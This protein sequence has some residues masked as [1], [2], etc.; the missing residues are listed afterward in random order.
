[1]GQPVLEQGGYDRYVV[2]GALLG[3]E[4][5]V[6][7]FLELGA[8][9]D[10]RDPVV[11]QRAGQPRAKALR[12]VLLFDVER[13]QIGVEV[14]AWTVHLL[15]S[16]AL[17]LC[18]TV[19]REVAQV[20]ERARD[21]DLGLQQVA[22]LQADLLENAHVV[23]YKCHT[24]S[25]AHVVPGDHGPKVLQH[26]EGAELR[27]VG[28]AVV[29]LL[30][31]HRRCLGHRGVALAFV[32]PHQRCAGVDLGVDHSEDLAH[33]TR[34]GSPYC[35]LHLH[36]LEDDDRRAGLDG[37]A[38]L[39][40]HR[41]HHG[42]RRGSDDAG[43]VVDDPAAG[44]V[45]DHEMAA[46]A[47][48]AAHVVAPP[49]DHESALVAV[50]PVAVDHRHLVVHIEPV[51]LRTD[52]GDGE[53][54][55]LALVGELD[56]ATDDVAGPRAAPACRGQERRT[57]H[58]LLG[59]VH[60]DGDT[61]Q[62]DVGVNRRRL[63]H[64]GT[65]PVE[66]LRVCLAGNDL[67]AREQ[68]EQER[69][70]RRPALDENGRLTQRTTQSGQRLGTVTPP[71]D[72]LRHHGVVLRGDDLAGCD[73]GVHPDA[74]AGGRDEDD[75]GAR[76]RREPLCGVLS[77]QPCLDGVAGLAGWLARQWFSHGHQELELDQVQSG[78]GLGDGVLHLEPCVDLH[79][80]KGLVLWLV[81]EL[82]RARTLV[83]GG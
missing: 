15:V 57:F 11:L 42:R 66:P 17:L 73:R 61:E 76:R 32:Q 31:V 3:H 53:G 68:V 79:E 5:A 65:D 83:P 8:P 62:G 77:V 34:S 30:E 6:D 52:L 29:V 40:A 12:E 26:R 71:G 81:E 63:G 21:G 55:G 69:R 16:R 18:G 44:A 47:G 37:V 9:L 13:V 46:R 10:L 56:L 25:C 41:H 45:D 74:R 14:L 33:D 4:Q 39:H 80:R 67:G 20:G 22:V 48:D 78:G 75:D 35:G 38:G 64:L 58:R 28:A 36:A 7:G 50:E 27:I 72:H 43:V 1:V 70:G 49:S 54:V 51:P 2:G 23:G 82:D 59:V 60:V 19:A 24:P